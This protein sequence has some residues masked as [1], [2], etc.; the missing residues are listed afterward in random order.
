MR[1]FALTFAVAALLCGATYFTNKDASIESAPVVAGPQQEGYGVNP[2]SRRYFE[3][4]RHHDPATGMV[5]RNMRN[6]VNEFAS[7]LP[8]KA[9]DRSLTWSQR[10]PI[11]KGGR[12]R[13]LAIDIT[14][15]N[16][17]LAGSVTGG[18]WR[19][20]DGG[21]NWT[22]TTAPDQMHSVSCVVQDTRPGHE[23]TWY[24]GTGEEFYGVV[25]GT[26]FTS[27][28]SGDGAYKSTDG[29]QTW[30]PLVSTS[31]NTPQ[32]IMQNGSY[33]FVWDMAIDPSNTTEDEVYAAVFNGIIRSTDGGESWTQVLGFGAVASEFTDVL[34]TQDGVVYATMSFGNGS[35]NGGFFRSEDG[36]TWTEL[37]PTSWYSQR[38]MVMASN[39][40]N[41]NE[42]YVI[43][44]MTNNQNDI[45]HVLYKYTYIEGDGSGA[46]G[47]MV[48]RSANLPDDDC[49]LQIGTDFDFGTFRSQNSYDLCITHHPTEPVLFIGGVNIHRSVSEF[50][51]DDHDWIGGYRCNIENPLDYSY[52]SHHSDQHLMVFHPTNPDVMFSANDGGL[53]RT[54]DVLADSVAWTPLNHGYITT[55][56]YTVAMEQ[57]YSDSDFVFGGMQ[58]NGT[59]LT[60]TADANANWKEVHADD[61]AYCALPQGRDFIL[62]SSQLGRMYKKTIDA[63]GHLTGTERIDQVNAPAALFINPFILD[64]FNHN[65]LYIAG[66]KTI[67]VLQGVSNVEVTN[68]YINKLDNSYWD[69]ISES[70]IAPSAGSI[71]CLD[72]A[73]IDNSKIYYGT[74][75]GRIY[76]LDDCYG[77]PI[78]TE[79]TPTDYP[80]GAYTSC[81][82]PNDLDVNE[83]IMSYS[84]YS[85]PS[86]FHSEDGGTTWTNISGNLEQNLDGTGNGPAVYWV[87]IYPGTPKV[88]FAGTSAGLYSTEELNGINTV[89]QMEGAETIGNVVIN[90]I[91]VRPYDGKIAI[92]THANGIYTASLP[93]VPAASVANIETLKSDV[94]VYP[95]PFSDFISWNFETRKNE[96]IFL[97]VFDLSGKLVYQSNTQ[98][99]AAGAQRLEWRPESN[100]GG[101]TYIYKLSIGNLNKV[102]KV[103]YRK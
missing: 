8:R 22:K 48:D 94:V 66:N 29:G 50:Q 6:A 40:S 85:I 4:L 84:N 38:R 83:V 58:D 86:I 42:I 12:T 68:D 7:R 64:P 46:G 31:S 11:N 2:G 28:Y 19:S 62:T 61:G 18:M 37:T 55:Q 44:E 95:N 34:V 13:A 9:A 54:D 59:W 89:W 78:Q 32:N 76:R 72:K 3:Y 79:I 71:T 1:T 63:E 57:G 69:N 70:L 47:T 91:K 52:P 10:G 23:N 51:Q 39:P 80:T 87:E 17:I 5:P 99:A 92:G 45:A 103:I 81:I 73:Q 21:T 102:G 101:G 14:N 53:Y 90:M 26:S 43:G 93:P 88:Y 20:T 77:D 24:F 15:T 30:E 74:S 35:Q 33:D 75:S 49:T 27:L 100:I 60:H 96:N 56:F 98:Q 36:L 67:R 16:T 65:D 97:Q 82:T 41:E 25:S